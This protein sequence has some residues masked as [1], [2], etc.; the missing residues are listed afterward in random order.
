MHVL[1]VYAHPERRSLNGSLRDFMVEHLRRA[2]HQVE[3]SDLYEMRWKSQLDAHDFPERDPA[4]H[5]DPIRDSHLAYT[6]GTQSED[7]A[8]EQAKL[9]RADAVILQFPL[10]SF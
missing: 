4:A 2:G 5:F 3:V 10:W 8:R 7:V 6:Q 9:M 1:I